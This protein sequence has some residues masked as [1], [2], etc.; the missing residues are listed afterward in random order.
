[1][2]LWL[3]HKNYV[4]EKKHATTKKI[5]KKANKNRKANPHLG[6]IKRPTG[7]DLVTALLVVQYKAHSYE[8]A[9]IT[10]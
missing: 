9:P 2:Q 8:S 6:N 10:T 7:F 3:N 1:M 5:T 4:T